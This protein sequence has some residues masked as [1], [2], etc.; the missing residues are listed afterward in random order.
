MSRYVLVAALVLGFSVPAMAAKNF[1][2]VRGADKKCHVVDTAPTSTT[3]TRVGKNTYVTQ[4]EAEA[5]MA[6]VCK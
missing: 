5:D 3:V 4:E 6:V 2:I 1:Y